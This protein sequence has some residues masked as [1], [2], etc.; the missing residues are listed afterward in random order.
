MLGT[1][2]KCIFVSH[3]GGITQVVHCALPFDERSKIVNMALCHICIKRDRFKARKGKRWPYRR[4]RDGWLKQ[5]EN[6]V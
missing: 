3:L 2:S 6:P 5:S 4:R 1:T